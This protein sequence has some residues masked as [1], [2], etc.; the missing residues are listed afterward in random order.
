MTKAGNLLP[1]SAPQSLGYRSRP[2]PPENRYLSPCGSKVKQKGRGLQ[3][4]RPNLDTFQITLSF[5]LPISG[6][7]IA[8]RKELFSTNSA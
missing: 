4:P 7:R 8:L 2:A 6:A 1:A 5:S 3:Y